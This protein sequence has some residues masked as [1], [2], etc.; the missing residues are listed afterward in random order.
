MEVAPDATGKHRL[1]GEW[2]A[3][4]TKIAVPGPRPKARRPK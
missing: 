4:R 3:F 1:I 2:H